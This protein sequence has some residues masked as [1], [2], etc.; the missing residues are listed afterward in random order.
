MHVDSVAVRIL[1]QGP[2][3][4]ASIHTPL[5]DSQLVRFHR[6][7]AEVIGRHL[8]RGVVIEVSALDVLDS[9]GSRTVCD[10]AEM[11][12]LRGAAPV[13]AGIQPHVAF[14]MAS[15]GLGTGSI[16]TAQDLEDGLR[17]LD[18]RCGPAPQAGRAGSYLSTG[19]PRRGRANP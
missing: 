12:R 14:A 18:Q 16:P 13:I 8:V 17:L 5:D 10:V 6:D 1:R 7:L 9:F 4:V 3:L 11:V 2:Y 15:L 19:A